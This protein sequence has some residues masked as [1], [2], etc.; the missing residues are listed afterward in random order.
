MV[1]RNK[2]HQTIRRCN[3]T[4]T[5]DIFL[6]RELCQIERSNVETTAF[7]DFDLKLIR[8]VRNIGCWW[9]GAIETKF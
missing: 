2:N 3:Y 9:H 5:D 7:F 6:C 4:L 1:G 8:T